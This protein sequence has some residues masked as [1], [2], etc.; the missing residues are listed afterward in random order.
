MRGAVVRFS[1]TKKECFLRFCVLASGSS[2]NC[3]YVSSGETHI[4]VDAGISCKEADRRLA[5]NGVD[6][7]RIQAVC[8]THEHEDHISA[9]GVMQRKRGVSLYANS[10]TIEAINAAGKHK[11]LQWNVFEAGQAFEIGALKIEP[12]SV[13]HDAYDPVGFCVSD[14]A[15]RIGIATDMGMATGLVRERLKG[16][17]VIVVESNHDTEMLNASGRPW[18]LK[19]RIGGRHGHMS[20]SQACEL[21]GEVA[22]PPLKTVYLAHISADCNK[23]E[24]VLKNAR[25]V[26]DSKGM[27]SVAVE[28]TY[29]DRPTG[30]IEF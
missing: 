15:T 10:A 7:E 29:A 23:C 6:P 8:V 14:G 3:A 13:P 5:E 17:S 16:C 21:L 27:G 12:F 22:A 26:L 2:G 19:Q 30:L 18:S 20:N 4:L 25:E 28:L 1:D 9:I 11:G 24:A